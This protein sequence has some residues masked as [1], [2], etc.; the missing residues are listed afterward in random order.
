MSDEELGIFIEDE[1]DYA[2]FI[3]SH[4]KCYPLHGHTAKLKIELKGSRKDFDMI[5]DFGSLRKIVK[6]VLSIYDHKLIA[7]EKY[8]KEYFEDKVFISYSDFRIEIPRKN[9]Y[10]LKKE[11]TTENLAED[12]SSNLLKSLPDN[13]IEVKVEIYE[14]ARKGAFKRSKR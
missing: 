8:I 12:I 1:F 7:S 5:L 3:P 11:V 4:P 14:G 2:H 9:V 10:I 13:V 6:E